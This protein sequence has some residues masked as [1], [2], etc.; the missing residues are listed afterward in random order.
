MDL[1]ELIPP[2]SL[3]YD[4]SHSAPRPC[5]YA[6]CSGTP[7]HTLMMHSIVNK[8]VSCASWDSITKANRGRKSNPTEIIYSPPDCRLIFRLY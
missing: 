4:F 2:Y 6:A 3:H 7:L 5:H 8:C 1:L